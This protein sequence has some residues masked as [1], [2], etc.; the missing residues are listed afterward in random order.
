VGRW[1]D[2]K[3][4]KKKKCKNKKRRPSWHVKNKKG[5]N[6]Q[7]EGKKNHTNYKPSKSQNS[8]MVE[9]K[10]VKGYGKV[11]SRQYSKDPLPS[12]SE[13]RAAAR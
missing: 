9:G 13:G 3:N 8:K 1:G 7:D 5:K 2:T 12:H 11:K 10:I 4:G 6:L